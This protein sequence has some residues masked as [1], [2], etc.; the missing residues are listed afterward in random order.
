MKKVKDVMMSEEK[1]ALRCKI[2]DLKRLK[3]TRKLAENLN[4]VA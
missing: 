1:S 3:A 2:D 4:R